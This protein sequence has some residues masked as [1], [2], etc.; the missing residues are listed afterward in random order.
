MR[1]LLEVASDQ[2]DLAGAVL[3]IEDILKP[4]TPTSPPPSGS[5][6]PGSTWKSPAASGSLRPTT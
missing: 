5:P 4:A 1:V 2:D 6:S 3:H